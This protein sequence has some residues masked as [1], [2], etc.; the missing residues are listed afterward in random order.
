MTETR[1]FAF[2]GPLSIFPAVTG[3]DVWVNGNGVLIAYENG[4]AGSE[5]CFGQN[6]NQK[7]FGVCGICC[8]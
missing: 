5:I 7:N 3:N 6:R 8:V 2:I 1:W 4:V